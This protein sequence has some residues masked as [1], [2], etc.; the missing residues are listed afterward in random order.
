MSRGPCKFTQRDMS[1]AIKAT[2][3]AGLQP[4]RVEVHNDGTIVIIVASRTI[5]SAPADLVEDGADLGL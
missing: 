3:E 1:V 4:E 5:D 2:V